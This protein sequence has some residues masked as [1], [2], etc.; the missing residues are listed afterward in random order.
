MTRQGVEVDSCAGCGGV[1]LDKGEIFYFAAKPKALTQELNKA[2]AFSKPGDLAS[3]KTGK[4]MERMI[5]FDQVEIDQCPDTRG[6]WLDRGE[7]RQIME[8]AD[9]RLSLQMDQRVG[10]G[11][12]APAALVASPGALKA[13]AAAGRPLPNLAIRSFG[14]L[15]FLYGLLT[16]MLIALVETTGLSPAVAVLIGLG[17]AAFQFGLGPLIMDWSLRI[18][19][20][21]EWVSPEDLP[22]HLRGFIVRVMEKHKKRLPRMGIIHDGAPNAFT[23]GHHPGNARVVLTQGLIDLL[24]EKE[25][26]AVVAHELG[27]ALRWDMLIMTMAYLVPLIAYYIYRTMVSIRVR[28]R[29]KTA[30]ARL[31]I[32]L[33]AFVV[34]II[35]EYI[36]LWLSRTREFGADRFAGEATGEPNAL[37]RALVKIGYGLAGR[38]SEKQRA[39]AEGAPQRAVGME[40]LGAMGIANAGAGRALAIASTRLAGADSEVSKENLKGAMRWDLWNPWAKFY[41]L[42]STHPLIASRLDHL[43]RQ[44]AKMGQEPHVVFDDKKPESYWDEFLVDVFV[45]FLPWLLPLGVLIVG[46]VQGDSRIMATALSAFGLGLLVKTL[47]S[48]RGGAFPEMNVAGLLKNVKV[49]A[50]RGVPC[51]LHGTVIGR[52][53]PGLIY[54]EDFVV[55][56]DTGLMF[57]DYRQPLRIWEFLFGLMRRGH[58][59]GQEITATGWYRRAPMPYVELRTLQGGGKTRRCYTMHAKIVFS[60]LVTAAGIL[61]ALHV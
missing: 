47:F 23:Y 19:Y 5:L 37:S 11:A 34:Y 42:A 58:L 35:S 45:V 9:A 12:I 1:W 51:T 10:P 40:A 16:L 15:A 49:S 21:C 31:A 41:E 43:S 6:L 32:A 61:L 52:G 2:K 38:P 25:L 55:R 53:V 13:Y 7:M 50:V 44:A 8:L 60:A 54:S 57:L 33:G 14:V 28:G 46:G 59:D 39:K 17:I 4:P 24:D 18:F 26:E 56:D 3:P 27:H 36:V 22:P 20:R 48:Y 30:G 29:D